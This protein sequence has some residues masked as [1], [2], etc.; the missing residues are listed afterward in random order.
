M[1]STDT[2]LEAYPSARTRH[3][4]EVEITYVR[5]VRNSQGSGII[6]RPCNKYRARFGLAIGRCIIWMRLKFQSV[7]RIDLED[8]GSH[9][10]WPICIRIVIPIA[11]VNLKRSGRGI[12]PKGHPGGGCP[13]FSSAICNCKGCDARGYLAV[14]G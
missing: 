6:S 10:T 8:M 12:V 5:K 13:S 2:K 4:E 7:F 3:E 11:P 1:T 9:K 14:A